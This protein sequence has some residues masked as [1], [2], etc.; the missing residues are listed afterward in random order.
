MKYIGRKKRP[1]LFIDK[2]S[3]SNGRTVLSIYQL[4]LCIGEGGIPQKHK[5][6]G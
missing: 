3:S 1:F 4:P 5:D 6:T 2:H